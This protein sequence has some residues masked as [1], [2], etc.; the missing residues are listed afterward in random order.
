MALRF[1]RLPLALSLVA[2]LSLSSALTG[3]ACAA[4]DLSPSVSKPLAAADS[5]LSAK[6]YAKA[7]EAVK[8]ADAVSG[9]TAYDSYVIEQMR[10]AIAAQSGDVATMTDAY[11][12]VI[13]SPRT[14]K[15]QKAQMLQA[16]AT[17]AYT[18]K[19]YARAVTGFERYLKQIG[20]NAAIE[21]YL[22]QSY[23]LQKDY[24]NAGRIQKQLVEETLKAKKVPAENDL[25]MLA[26][27]QTQVKDTAGQMHSYV[28]LATYY[29]KPD[30]WAQL[31]HALVTNNSLPPALQLDVYRV[32]LAAG[33]LTQASDFLDA[34]EIAVQSGVPK[35]GLDI[36]TQGYAAGVL[37]KDP[38]AARQAKLKDF[39]AATVEKKKASI[40]ADEAAALKAPTGD[41]LLTVGYN[42]VTFGETD[43]G[44][45]LMQQGIAK[46]VR[47]VNIARLHLGEAQMDA[48]RTADAVTTLRTVDG[49][50][51]AKD[52]AQLWILKIQSGTRK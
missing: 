40:A 31:L 5:A 41:A 20:P 46:G 42:Y 24:A 51:G 26:T 29:P 44:V 2:G 17:T 50:N 33:N 15:E 14:S 12:K 23:Y 4:D 34:A 45:G 6:N 49:T 10:G 27:C 1:S 47:D 39:I 35:T 36:L 7:M 43:K 18:A 37:G 8:A 13:A 3:V 25:L 28:L 52:I 19:D 48:G 22:V 32:R 30:Y 9:K 21:K 16:E 11:D 38:G